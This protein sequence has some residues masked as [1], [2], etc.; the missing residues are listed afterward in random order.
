MKEQRLIGGLRRREKSRAKLCKSSCGEIA[1]PYRRWIVTLL[2]R[3]WQTH[4]LYEDV[5]SFQSNEN[6]FVC[7]YES[8]V[9]WT[10]E[11]GFDSLD[12][13][14]MLDNLSFRSRATNTNGKIHHHKK[15][16]SRVRN[17]MWL[18][19]GVH[20]AKLLSKLP[21]EC[22]DMVASLLDVD[23][24]SDPIIISH[25]PYTNLRSRVLRKSCK[26]F[27]ACYRFSRLRPLTR[28]V[29]PPFTVPSFVSRSAD[30]IINILYRLG[31]RWAC[32]K[33]HRRQCFEK[34]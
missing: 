25:I 11:L 32:E 7:V 12:V 10:T 14:M 29:S 16:W 15:E 6:E 5:P 31:V 27:S 23:S 20:V 18:P 28:D 33:E 3:R 26:S 19:A 22:H 13:I 2:Y 34:P 4:R 9:W 21:A 8:I 17:G 30:N 1:L 24:S